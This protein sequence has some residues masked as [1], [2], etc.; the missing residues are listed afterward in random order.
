M[1]DMIMILTRDEVVLRHTLGN[2][3]DKHKKI[4]DDLI[5]LHGK[6]YVDDL[7]SHRLKKKKLALK[8]QI[9]QL[10]GILKPNIIA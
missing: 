3:C 4:E 1:G 6:P 10:R 8:D 5:N 2:L 9:T 7:L